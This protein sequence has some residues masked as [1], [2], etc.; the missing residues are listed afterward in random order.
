MNFPKL[1]TGLQTGRDSTRELAACA[2]AGALGLQGKGNAHW[3]RNTMEPVV[4]TK[5]QT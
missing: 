4:T 2:A 1:I 5:K 3:S